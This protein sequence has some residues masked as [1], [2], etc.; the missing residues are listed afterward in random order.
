MRRYRVWASFRESERVPSYADGWVVVDAH[1][2]EDAR[3]Q[4]QNFPSVYG[5]YGCEIRIKAVE[6]TMQDR[7]PLSYELS[8]ASSERPW[9]NPDTTTTTEG[10]LLTGTPPGDSVRPNGDPVTVM[11]GSGTSAREDHGR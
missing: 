7:T 9:L 4:V 2:A 11:A 1:D 3:Y 6:P 5:I 10:P 8:P